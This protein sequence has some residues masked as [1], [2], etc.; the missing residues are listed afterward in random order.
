[1]LPP[2]TNIKPTSVDLYPKCSEIKINLFPLGV[3]KAPLDSYTD[4]LERNFSCLY[5]RCYSHV[6]FDD[7]WRKIERV[8]KN[9]VNILT[10]IE[11][12]ISSDNRCESRLQVFWPTFADI[13]AADYYPPIYFSTKC[14]C[15]INARL[16]S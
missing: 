15:L 6:K 14:E 13:L 4:S 10:I 9:N 3:G 7:Y 5:L 2:L 11:R 12:W 16:L 1:M 8:K